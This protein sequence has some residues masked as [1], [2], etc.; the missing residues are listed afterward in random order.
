MSL[1][2]VD[3]SQS[4]QPVADLPIRLEEVIS[5]VIFWGLAILLFAQFFSRYALDASL[6]W[7]EELARYL[8]ILLA[9]S[10]ASIATKNDAHIGVTL[11][12]RYLPGTVLSVLQLCIAALNL[13]VVLLLMVY[14][15]Q[16]GL[17]LP[18]YTLAS[19]PISMSWFYGLIALFLL[20][21]ASRSVLVMRYRW[22]VLH[23]VHITEVA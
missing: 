1:S 14:A 7:S 6:G 19:L 11:L 2:E 17:A 15:S 16:I 3:I 21:M 9:F 18:L 8:L 20:L 4:E 12:H 13:A 10:G 23:Q 5:L 22:R